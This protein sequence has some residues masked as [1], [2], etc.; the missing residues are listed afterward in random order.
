[1]KF[2]QSAQALAVMAMTATSL[3]TSAQS[4]VVITGSREPLAADRL[5]ADVVVIDAQTLRSTTADSLGDVLRREAG[6]QLIRTGGPGQGTTAMIRGA[7]G[8][9][10]V[11]LVDGVRVGSATLGL[12]ALEQISLSSVDR[13]EVLRGPGSSLYGADAVGG[14]V[15][16]FTKRG[17]ELSPVSA[18]VA[19]GGYGSR[20]WSFSAGTKQSVWEASAS[21]SK[22][23]SRGVSV[24]R[25]GDRFGNY[26][27]DT[28]GYS[29]QTVQAQ[30]GF[31]PSATQ[32]L[33]LSVMRTSLNAQYDASDYLPP[34]Y[35]PNP[36]GDF[37]NRVVTEVAAL[38]WK[39]Q[40]SGWRLSAR[41]AHSADDAVQGA[42]SPDR[43]RTSRDQA[44]VQA[45][46]DL[47]SLGQAVLAIEQ[48]DEH[49]QSSGYY[50][51]VSRRNSAA[52]GAW[53][54]NSGPWSWQVD[55]RHDQS[56]DFGGVNTARWGGSWAVQPG[57]KVRFL[58]GTT[59]RAPSFND[60]V[61][62]G[63]GVPTLRPER[64]QSFE[65]GTQWR[66]ASLYTEATVFQ[67]RVKDLIGY[68]GDRTWCPSDPAYDYGCARNINR[69]QLQGL[70]WT[71][72]WATGPWD[73]KA[74]WEFLDAKDVLRG[75]RLSRRAAQQGQ[76][77]MQWSRQEW[78]WSATLL[79]LGARPDA[80]VTLA[81]ETTLNLL[82]Q[83]QLLPQW[84]LQAKLVN[85]TD[86][87][88]VPA[89]DY[90]GLGRQAWIVL[91]YEAQGR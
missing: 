88:I 66:A 56:N 84:S 13:I 35:M 12:A 2:S 31:K 7:N 76:L 48:L 20:T 72:G 82:G 16:I 52:V 42:A 46:T 19:Q 43:Y 28:D 5:A 26:N 77:R 57:L 4:Q 68:E 67:N 90:Q 80:G 58:W 6:V 53:T 51:P 10:T 85:A 63:Y 47:A 79:H 21:V 41:A 23:S 14:V 49:A 44:S 27:P 8:G 45:A 11:V 83:W 18:T 75:T 1:M 36:S 32:R 89:R 70:S 65:L 29:L 74:H 25:P 40:W 17:D 9:Q 22:E 3:A 87:K 69:A 39:G 78:L 15:Q 81:A 91:R 37:R 38:D 60:L 73:L 55:A 64:G 33:G 61:Y 62:P 34:D 54:G 59:F 30:W 24:L 86:Q 50:R 71:A